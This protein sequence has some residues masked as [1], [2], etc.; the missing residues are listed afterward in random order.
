M[1]TSTSWKQL[2][3]KVHASYEGIVEG[4]TPA[5]NQAADQAAAIMLSSARGARTKGITVR[6]KAFVSGR[7]P[8]VNVKYG[9]NPGWVRIMNDRTQPHLIAPSGKGRGGSL[10][11]Q[12]LSGVRGLT[13]R[14]NARAG[15][16]LLAALG[17]AF[18]A[19][20]ST[21]LGGRHGKAVNIRGVGPRAYANHPGTRGKHFA[22]RGIRTAEPAAAKTYNSRQLANFGKPF[23]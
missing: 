17:G 14:R 3:G 18:G 20:T 11:R 8:A 2:T 6:K 4:T 22:G 13:G 1:G 10:R 19:E 15:R 21:G 9:P 7:N 5:L 23:K 12:N 16:I